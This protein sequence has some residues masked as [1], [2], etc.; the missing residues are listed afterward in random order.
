MDC[1]QSEIAIMQHVEK[2]I[3][4]EDARQLAKHVL[5]CKTCREDY[6]MFDEII[7]CLEDES[8]EIVSAPEGFTA[9]VMTKV[10]D[11]VISAEEFVFVK[12]NQIA[13]SGSNLVTRVLWGFSAVFIGIGLYFILNP[14]MFAALTATSPVMEGIV[15]SLSELGIHLSQ[16]FQQ[17]ALADY[18]VESGVGIMALFFVMILGGLLAVLHHN[19]QSVKEWNQT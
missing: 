2:T 15:T 11:S 16:G 12:Q 17:L 19:E 18:A 1:T 13:V 5:T 9:S 3:T 10:R 8:F 4:P 6:L 14:D 7:E